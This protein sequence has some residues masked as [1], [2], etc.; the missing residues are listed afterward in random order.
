MLCACARLPARRRLLDQASGRLT[1]HP[2]TGVTTCPRLSH[3]M[4]LPSSTSG[5]K[6]VRPPGMA[7]TAATQPRAAAASTSA[8]LAVLAARAPAAPSSSAAPA[9][10]VCS[11]ARRLAYEAA[12]A[13]WVCGALGVLAS[14][15]WGFCLA[16]SLPLAVEQAAVAAAAAEAVCEGCARIRHAAAAILESDPSCCRA[17]AELGRGQQRAGLKSMAAAFGSGSDTIV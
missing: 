10:A 16:M 4:P 8:P 2:L 14:E 13:A 1:P 6:P 15:G 5:V 3:T 12:T 9:A 7:D 17:R 11:S